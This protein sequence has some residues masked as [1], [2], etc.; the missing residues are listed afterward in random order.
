LPIRIDGE[1]WLDQGRGTPEAIDRSLAD[2]GRINRWL[3]GMRG[4]A[5]YLYPRIRSCQTDHV[6]VLDLGAGGCTIPATVAR[7]ARHAAISLE[8][9]ALDLR[10]AHLRWARRNLQ[11]WSEIAFIQVMCML[12]RLLKAASIS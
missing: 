1:E 5:S 11:T 2:L 4:L 6:R 12:C 10:Y 7:W 9:Y 8:I 3:G